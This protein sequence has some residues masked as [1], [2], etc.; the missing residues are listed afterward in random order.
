MGKR[1]F[2][3][4]GGTHQ[5]G[6]S[7]FNPVCSHSYSHKFY[8]RMLTHHEFIKGWLC[9]NLGQLEKEKQCQFPKNPRNFFGKI[10]QN[11]LGPVYIPYPAI[12][13]STVESN[14]PREMPI[15][16]DK[17]KTIVLFGANRNNEDLLAGLLS[18]DNNLYVIKEENYAIVYNPRDNQWKPLD[19]YNI[20]IETQPGAITSY[21]NTLSKPMRFILTVDYTDLFG[22]LFWT[23]LKF[24]AH[25]NTHHN[26]L[27]VMAMNI[28][29]DDVPLQQH[30]DEIEGIIQNS[31]TMGQLGPF[32]VR[33][34]HEIQQSGKITEIPN[35]SHELAAVKPALG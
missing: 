19:K 16:K 24:I 26:E 2:Y 34:L 25:D 20:N 15:S 28:P 23:L 29:N 1:D 4:N 8:R 21:L 30:I 33:G 18:D 35:L 14:V 27:V 6:C 3:L 5:P 9:R 22:E 13:D 32:R 11:E 31:D 12:N 7:S 10:T 17:P